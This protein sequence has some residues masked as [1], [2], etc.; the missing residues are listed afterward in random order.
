MTT[1]VKRLH[2]ATL[3]IASL[4]IALVAFNATAQVRRHWT[5][6]V[7][8]GRVIIDTTA[9]PL[10]APQKPDA[11]RA[12]YTFLSIDP[13][14]H[15][16]CYVDA[17]GL[18]DARQVVVDWS[19]PTND[20]NL[21]HAWLLADG[22]W[23]SLDF[24][25]SH[26][27]NLST[28]FTSLNNRGIAFGTYWSDCSFEPAVG[29]NVTTRSWF[30]L[31]DIQDFPYNAG[32][33]MSNNG[34]AVGVANNDNAVKHWI[35]NGRQY[36]FPNFPA[37]WDVSGIWAGPLFIN[38]SGHIAGQYVDS[39]GRMRGYFQDGGR[40]TTFEAPGNPL[41]T[42][43]NGI[44]D[45]GNLLLNGAY[46]ESSPYYPSHS[47]SW[48]QGVFTPL[49][50]VPFPGAVLTYVYGL[51]NPGDISGVW[52]DSSNLWHAFVAYRK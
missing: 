25:H 24:V 27:P 39:T 40:V 18:N 30:A 17:H 3:W 23:T 12:S 35:W 9:R 43:V 5:I 31:P 32:F 28:Y 48:R 20:C 11:D 50:T 33:S 52:Q 45:S 21:M 16:H 8:P 14:G 10:A 34:L 44:T 29:I 51:N 42:Y 13:Q 49:P 26:C 47:F 7:N 22:K 4:G 19:E 2:T 38:D 36:L 6:P 15:G 41:G 46:D 37:G 1:H